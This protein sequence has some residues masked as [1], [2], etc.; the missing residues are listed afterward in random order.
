MKQISIFALFRAL[1]IMGIIFHQTR[2][3]GK[4]P[5]LVQRESPH[6]IELSMNINPVVPIHDFEHRVIKKLS[7]PEKIL[8]AVIKNHLQVVGGVP[9]T[10]FGMGNI[11]QPD[12]TTEFPRKHVKPNDETTIIVVKRIYPIIKKGETVERF[13]RKKSEPAAYYSIKRVKNPAT[14]DFYWES[15]K[16]ETPKN[17]SI[18]VEA[19]VIC[20]KP[21][22]I[23]I[24]EIT[25][26]AIAGQNLILPT[27]YPTT[28]FRRGSPVNT[29][30]FLKISKYFE[31]VRKA[32]RFAKTQD[33]KNIDRVAVMIE[34]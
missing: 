14:N 2:T 28:L 12:A 10:Y 11:L 27:I 25:T 17:L 24:P 1:C 23:Y 8:R 32:Y 26:S 30:S 34:A 15:K 3:I 31:P 29:M 13:I 7:E 5:T 4:E 20:A 33:D 18:P 9:V 22:E 21:D 19:I 16:L 6:I